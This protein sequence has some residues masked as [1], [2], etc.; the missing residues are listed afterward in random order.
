[1]KKQSSDSKQYYE[2]I[3]KLI[4]KYMI[5][6]VVVFSE[7]D[8]FD[9]LKQNNKESIK[10]YLHDMEKM[11]RYG[12]EQ[13]NLIKQSIKDIGGK[14]LLLSAKREMILVNRL[15][16]ECDNVLGVYYTDIENPY[17]IEEDV[18]SKDKMLW[19]VQASRSKENNQAF[20]SGWNNSY[21]N[22]P[23]TEEEL[24]EYVDN[25][26]HKLFSYSGGKMDALE[27]GVGSGLIACKLAPMFKTYDGC[28]ISSV[29]L[30]KLAQIN[31]ENN[32]SNMELYNYGAN[33]IEKIGKKYDVILMSSV[34]EYFSGYNYMR[35]VVQKCINC[36]KD[37]GRIFIGDVFD[38]G[39]KT[40]YENSVSEYA[41]DNPGAR[42]KK[43]F[44][45][46]LFIP[47]EYWLDIMSSFDEIQSVEVTDKYGEI[48]N[49]INRFRYDVLIHVRKKGSTS[50]KIR[51]DEISREQNIFGKRMHKYQFAG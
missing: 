37:E 32:V 17:E 34:T 7:S 48:E 16:W 38:L 47:M 1:M 50:G 4:K 40:E 15:L 36:L 46:E 20:M 9:F 29:V 28:D 42:A 27:V 6:A 45:H 22:E 43:N 19:D 35:E 39:T 2:R 23:F 24:K 41:S 21:N 11:I 44:S 3:Q 49:E 8:F 18:T 31:S 26:V 12:S 25:S 5:T 14:V 51:K 10:L 30:S 13:Y 33:E